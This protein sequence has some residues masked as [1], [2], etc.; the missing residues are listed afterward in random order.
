MIFIDTNRTR[1]DLFNL[2]KLIDYRPHRAAGGTSTLRIT[3]DGPAVT[4][5]NLPRWWMARSAGI[6][7]QYHMAL[8]EAATIPAGQSTVEVDAVQGIRYSE[9]F[10]GTGAQYQVVRLSRTQVSGVSVTVDGVEWTETDTMIGRAADERVFVTRLNWDD[11]VQ[12]EFGNGIEGAIPSAGAGTITVTYL[13][14]LGSGGNDIGAGVITEPA[15]AVYDGSTLITSKV[16]VENLTA[17]TGGE[18]EESDA[19]V[20]RNAPRV[21]HTLYR[22]GPANDIRSLLEAYPGI[23]RVQVLDVNNYSE[24]V[25][26]HYAEAYIIPEGGGAMSE[27]LRAGIEAYIDERREPGFEIVVQG[28][29]Y[30]PVDVTVTI[31]RYAGYTDAEVQ[32]TVT[33]AL[34]NYFS[35]DQDIGTVDWM[36]PVVP[37]DILA[38]IDRLEGVSYAELGAPSSA[39]AVGPGQFPT[40]GKLTMRIVEAAG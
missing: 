8:L 13:V 16:A 23:E 37:A 39:V 21:T 30:V 36:T 4:G 22:M 3:L 2:V 1:D 24:I 35:A 15:E 40:L 33:A 28:V 7:T 10:A 6:G 38:R 32:S 26:Y 11:T 29:E 25:R 18:D 17:V 14:T 12:I 34:Q 31:Y 27:A 9:H 20:K 19:D 5:V